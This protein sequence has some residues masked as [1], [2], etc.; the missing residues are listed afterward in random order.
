MDMFYGA[1]PDIFEKAKTLRCNLTQAEK[2][3]W[4]ELRSK[5]AK[6]YRF[7]RQHPIAFFI[8]DFY[9]HQA[10]LVIEIDVSIHNISE[11]KDYDIGRSHELE[12]LGLKILRFTNQEVMTEKE[13]VLKQI[14]FHLP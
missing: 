11:Q 14:L 3:L 10:K 7:K 12:N 5:K 9:C 8:A 1:S 13:E 6:G 4:K 2:I